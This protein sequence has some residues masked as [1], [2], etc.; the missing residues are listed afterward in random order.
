MVTWMVP[1]P[2]WGRSARRPAASGGASVR[3][4]PRS[5]NTTRRGGGLTGESTLRSGPSPQS[6]SSPSPNAQGR[7]LA[8]TAAPVGGG[9]RLRCELEHDSGAGNHLRFVRRHEPHGDA[10]TTADAE[11][12]TARVAVLGADAPHQEPDDS[13]GDERHQNCVENDHCALLPSIGPACSVLVFR[14]ADPRHRLIARP[15]RERLLVGSSDPPGW[16]RIGVAP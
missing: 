12:L 11:L 10:Q 14:L 3:S 7:S 5:P 6:P 4:P 1:R 15:N 13:G 8:S 2:V 9:R 16:V